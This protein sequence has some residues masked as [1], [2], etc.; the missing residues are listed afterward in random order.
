MVPFHGTQ[1]RVHTSGWHKGSSRSY[2]AAV[3]QNL[4]PS[5]PR[6]TPR[7]SRPRSIP[8]RHESISPCA[9]E[10]KARFSRIDP[11]QGSHAHGLLSYPSSGRSSCATLLHTLRSTVGRGVDSITTT[12]IC[13]DH[14]YTEPPSPYVGDFTCEEGVV[15]FTY[16]TRRAIP[17]ASP[18]A[19]SPSQ[20]ETDGSVT[21]RGQT[22]ACR[23]GPGC[24]RRHPD[25]A[26]SMVRRAKP[27]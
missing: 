5:W 22:P 2:S 7:S 12:T 26:L 18:T 3:P 9:M 14:R 13:G 17:P 8:E 1:L 20:A 11:H 4:Q 15:G 25:G 23:P 10:L 16:A 6:G 19:P 24:A 21:C 27:R